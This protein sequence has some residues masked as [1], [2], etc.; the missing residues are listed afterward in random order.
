MRTLFCRK[1]EGHGQQVVLKGHAS[2]CP[3][4]ACTCKTCANVM[5]MRANAI[6]RR[7]RT[8]TSECGLVLKPVHFK[9]G[10]TR[11][12]VFPKFISEEECLPIPTDKAAQMLLSAQQK[13]ASVTPPN[14]DATNKSNIIGNLFNS[15]GIDL[16]TQT[17]QT[18]QDL[19]PLSKTISMRN[20]SKRTVTVDENCNS[21]PKRAHSHSPVMMDT[22]LPP[23]SS[24]G[25]LSSM[26]FQNSANGTNNPLP[27]LTSDSRTTS[28]Q[29]LPFATFPFVSQTSVST[30][31]P[32]TSTVT[33]N[34]SMIDLLFSQQRSTGNNNDLLS[35]LAQNNL[36]GV[37]SSQASP[38]LNELNNLLQMQQQQSMTDSMSLLNLLRNQ[39]FGMPNTP[40][41][42]NYSP[43]Y[44]NQLPQQQTAF[45]FVSTPSAVGNMR[46]N[47]SDSENRINFSE[48]SDNAKKA[49]RLTDFLMLS[50]EGCARLQDTK[51]QRFLAT[52]RELEKQMLHDDDQPSATFY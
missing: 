31:S 21:P 39:Q 17:F 14:G 38:N 48:F 7:Y 22:S 41:V 15:N 30:T 3:F 51:F 2:S 45:P 28:T 12:R 32:I 23:S 49:E 8:R 36:L 29:S 42:S 5:S 46:R 9:N 1:C 25:A 47:S 40:R 20:L 33:T 43:I 18:G 34:P 27:L 4:N 11:L 6:I 44:S 35:L 50:P 19:S 24:S 10:N 37:S 26:A 13:A 52:V 16:P